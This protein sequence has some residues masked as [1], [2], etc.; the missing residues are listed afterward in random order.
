MATRVRVCVLLRSGMW[1]DISPG[2]M[3]MR[4]KQ[5]NRCRGV[6]MWRCGGMIS[7]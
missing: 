6:D 5:E 1:K 7:G 4:E 2:C 3:R